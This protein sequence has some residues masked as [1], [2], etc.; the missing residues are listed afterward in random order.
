MPNNFFPPQSCSQ[1][2]F[3]PNLFLSSP[4]SGHSPPA[5]IPRSGV[6][7]WL[8]ASSAVSAL[9]PPGFHPYCKSLSCVNSSMLFPEAASLASSVSH[10]LISPKHFSQG[11]D[12]CDQHPHL[13]FPNLDILVSAD[14]PSSTSETS[15][16][17]LERCQPAGHSCRC[18]KI[19]KY[20][21]HVLAGCE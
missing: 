7:L 17:D 13:L 6:R 15:C 12:R 10:S 21:G 14:T 4:L 20:D 18:W 8:L 19:P 5:Q 3:L 9:H 16:N 1:A 11:E 2:W